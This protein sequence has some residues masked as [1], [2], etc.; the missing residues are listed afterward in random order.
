MKRNISIIKLVLLWVLAFLPLIVVLLCYRRLPA[1]IP[2]HWGID[3]RADTTGARWTMLILA[4]LGPVCTAGM[5]FI[6]R[7]DPKKENYSRFSNAYEIFILVFNLF[8]LVIISAAWA[9]ILY[10]N[11]IGIS[12]GVLITVTGNIMPKFKHNYFIGIRTPWTLEIGR[13]HV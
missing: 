6:R 2:T 3:G 9:E 4:G 13:A 10:P 7:I 8:I 1:E 5:F 11:T 12:A